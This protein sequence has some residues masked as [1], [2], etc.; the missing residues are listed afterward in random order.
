M[1]SRLDPKFR[2]SQ[3]LVMKKVDS[4]MGYGKGRSPFCKLKFT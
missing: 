3:P 4:P 1:E 2:M